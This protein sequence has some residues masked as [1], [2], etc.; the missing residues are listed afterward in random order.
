MGSRT[1]TKDDRTALLCGVAIVLLA[2][3]NMML[4]HLV[5]EPLDAHG[6][7]TE[8][9]I[10]AKAILYTEGIVMVLAPLVFLYSRFA[11]KLAVWTNR[12]S[13]DK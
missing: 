7:Y 2:C 3:V 12:G 9:A 13:G 10:V 4:I 8:G 1:W 11:A 6:R 5:T